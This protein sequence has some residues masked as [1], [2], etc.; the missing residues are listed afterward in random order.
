MYKLDQKNKHV[1]YSLWEQAMREKLK[2]LFEEKKDNIILKEHN[3][4]NALS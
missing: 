2:M 4:K 1:Q 3:K